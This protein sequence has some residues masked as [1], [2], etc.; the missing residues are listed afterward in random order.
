[1]SEQD[2]KAAKDLLETMATLSEEDKKYI[3]GVGEGLR[4]AKVRMNQKGE[5]T[6]TIKDI[7]HHIGCSP[8][9]IRSAAQR[10]AIDYVTYIPPRRKYGYGRYIVYPE[11]AKAALGIKEGEEES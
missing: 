2:K 3:L 6:M 10:G 1:M 4:I 7:A 11:K 5:E 8:Q 9:L